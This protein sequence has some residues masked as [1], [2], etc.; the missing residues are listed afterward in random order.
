MIIF[1]DPSNNNQVMAVYPDGT[2]STV[3]EARGFIRHEITDPILVGKIRQLQRDCQ[4][5]FSAEGEPSDVLP[6]VNPIQPIRDPTEV[7]R[8]E[9]RARGKVKL[10]A[11]GFTQEEIDALV[12]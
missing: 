2:V 7:P 5:V 1:T 12:R 4:I 11:L 6:V 3:W 10:L 9:A 8:E